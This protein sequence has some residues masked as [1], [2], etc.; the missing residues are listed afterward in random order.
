MGVAQSQGINLE[1]KPA[2]VKAAM[3]RVLSDVDESIRTFLGNERYQLYQNYNNHAASYLFLDQ[4]DRRLSYP[5]APL[6]ESLTEALLRIL[7]D[8]AAAVPAQPA[9]AHGPLDG[10]LDAFSGND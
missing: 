6:Q 4:L 1:E 9:A 3:T 2:A 5:D 10:V 7:Q 8:S